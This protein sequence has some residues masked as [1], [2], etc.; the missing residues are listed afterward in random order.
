MASDKG[1]SPNLLLT[2]QGLHIPSVSPAPLLAPKALVKHRL[3]SLQTSSLRSRNVASFRHRRGKTHQNG[4]TSMPDQSIAFIT[5]A[6]EATF[7]MVASETPKY[8]H[9]S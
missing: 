5:L 2:V 9:V 8:G 4:F 6:A 3:T 1:D 7:S